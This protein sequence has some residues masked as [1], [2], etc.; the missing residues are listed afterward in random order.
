MVSH[1]RQR[2]QGGNAP[3]GVYSGERPAGVV[4]E[5]P[6]GMHATSGGKIKGGWG[7]RLQHRMLRRRFRH[8]SWQ[9][10]PLLTLS[11]PFSTGRKWPCEWP[12]QLWR[13]AGGR[14]GGAAAGRRAAAGRLRRCSEGSGAGAG[15]LGSLGR[16]LLGRGENLMTCQTCHHFDS[17]NEFWSHARRCCWCR[18]RSFAPGMRLWWRWPNSFKAAFGGLAG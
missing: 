11:V 18:R 10:C 6:A 12:P 14:G 9:Q 16:R 13:A 8:Q 2:R 5:G 3:A 17:D 15:S 4:Q 1:G 7:V